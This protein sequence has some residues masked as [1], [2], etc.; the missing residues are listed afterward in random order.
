MA[1]KSLLNELSRNR[2]SDICNAINNVLRVRMSYNDKK[3]GKGKNERYILP[4][5]YGLTKNGKPA[6]RAYQTAG[7]TKRGIT[8]PP[9]PRKEPNWKLFLLDNIYSWSNGKKSFKEYG[10]VLISKGLNTQ[11]DKHLPTLFAITPFANGNVQVA[12]ETE[13]I[14]SKPLTK[15]DIKPSVSSQNPATTEKDKFVSAQ[16]KRGTS[17]DNTNGTNYVDNKVEAPDTT[18]ITKQQVSPAKP[19]TN[20]YNMRDL[21]GKFMKFPENPFASNKPQFDINSPEWKQEYDKAAGITSGPVT[22]GQV[23]GETPENDL[24]S[25]YKDMMNRMDNL[26]KDEEEK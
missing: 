2:D 9:N 20:R 12:K 15:T 19:S 10:P 13:P 8:N 14:T 25:T 16:D 5:A 4:V 3:G 23:D 1:N 17:I 22:K 18:P 11:G 6:I 7:S 21:S 26:Y 24:T